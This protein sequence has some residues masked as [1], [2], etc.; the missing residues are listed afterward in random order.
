MQNRCELGMRQVTVLTVNVLRIKQFQTLHLV[1]AGYL[2][3][4]MLRVCAQM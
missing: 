3:G 2:F 4:Q 1:C